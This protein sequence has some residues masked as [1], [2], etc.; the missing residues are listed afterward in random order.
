MMIV[1]SSGYCLMRNREN[2]SYFFCDIDDF[3]RLFC[4]KLYESAV[5]ECC[6][7]AIA[8]IIC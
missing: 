2:L 6:A 3:L 5:Q 1:I 8:C 7:V 4:D